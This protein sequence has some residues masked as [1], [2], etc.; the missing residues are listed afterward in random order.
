MKSISLLGVFTVSSLI[1]SSSFYFSKDSFK[2]EKR[3]Q[4]VF[5]QTIIHNIAGEGKLD[6]EKK[7][8][9]LSY[10]GYPDGIHDGE[11]LNIV[12]THNKQYD[13]VVGHGRKITT[14]KRAV[15]EAYYPGREKL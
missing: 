13:I 14:V 3:E 2:N 5:S 11:D 6:D 9:F 4:D 8:L 10:L 1:V 15:L 12:R 7:K